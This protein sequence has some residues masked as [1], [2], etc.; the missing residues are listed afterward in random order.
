MQPT[1]QVIPV[2]FVNDVLCEGIL[3]LASSMRGAM[4][5]IMMMKWVMVMVGWVKNMQTPL[6][7]IPV[8]FTNDVLCEGVL[9]LAS[10]MRG[11]TDAIIMIKFVMVEFS[12]P[13]LHVVWV[14]N[15]QRPL[16]VI[17]VACV[18]MIISVRVC[19]FW[20]H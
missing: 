18:G 10:L 12:A 19:C 1:L 5:A 17:P 3:F 8:A 4:K 2:A 15:M 13:L 9:F 6:Q 11:A 7:M 20:C 14:K 16:Q